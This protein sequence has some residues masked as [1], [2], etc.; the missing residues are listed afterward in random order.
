MIVLLLPGSTPSVAQEPPNPAPPIADNS[1][2]LEEAYNQE[3]GVVQH[4]SAFQRT[5]GSAQWTYGF[6]QEWPAKSQRHQLSITLPIQRSEAP[7]GATGLGDV[8]LNYRIQL[9]GTQGAVAVAPRVSLLLPTGSVSKSHGS[10]GVGIQMNL[11][12]SV[13]VHRK[14]VTHWNAGGTLIPAARDASGARARLLG[15]NL[16]ASGV[17]L[18]ANR[19]NLLVETLWTRVESVTGAG[20]TSAGHAWWINPGIRWAHD[21]HSGLQIVPGISFP[22]GVGPSHGE[23]GLLIYLSFEHPF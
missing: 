6:V 11:P 23:Y 9:A 13:L 10:G 22:V 19:V 2:L 4:I 15:V 21:F 14:F 18:V 7:T 20:R 12:V 16:G 8:A 3:A 5:W 17:W 1:F